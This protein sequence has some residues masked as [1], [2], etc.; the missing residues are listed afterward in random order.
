MANQQGLDDLSIFVL[1]QTIDYFDNFWKTLK[2]WEPY[3]RVSIFEKLPVPYWSPAR[4][5]P[6]LDENRQAAVSAARGRNWPF[7]RATRT[8]AASGVALEQRMRVFFEGSGYTFVKVLGAGSQ[9]VAALFEFAGQRVVIKWSQELPALAT[10]IWAMRKMVG[11]RHI[12]QV[13]ESSIEPGLLV[14]KTEAG[15]GELWLGSDIVYIQRKWRPGM[16]ETD[17]DEDS[18]M[19]DMILTLEKTYDQELLDELGPGI[20]L[21]VTSFPSLF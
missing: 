17:W 18:G 2:T 19:M 3:E 1:Q 8:D 6:A 7:H 15:F 11:A 13:S 12:V 21:M 10:E 16:I 5:D 9:G 20:P 14:C 4:P